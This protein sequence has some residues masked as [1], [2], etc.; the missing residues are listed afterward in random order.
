MNGLTVDRHKEELS[1]ELFANNIVRA[2]QVFLENPNETP[3]IATWSRVH[4]ADPELMADLVK[5]VDKDYAEL[6]A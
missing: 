1:I 4:S 6:E 2:G 5:A 3:F